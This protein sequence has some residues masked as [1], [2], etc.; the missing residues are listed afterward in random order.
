MCAPVVATK[1]APESGFSSNIFVQ[2]LRRK[3]RKCNALYLL[4]ILSGLQLEDLPL[5][6]VV[7]PDF[8][9]TELCK[10]GKLYKRR[11]GE[12]NLN[13][14]IRWRVDRQVEFSF[15][16][17]ACGVLHVKTRIRLETTL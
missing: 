5:F 10:D 15:A 1:G 3:A 2:D 16:S 6:S 14:H 12:V 9:D 7:A 17:N 11:I 4:D 13:H 8:W